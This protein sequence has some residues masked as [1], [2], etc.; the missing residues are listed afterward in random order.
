M[1]PAAIIVAIVFG[2]LVGWGLGF[3]LADPR[4]GLVALVGG[5][6]IGGVILVASLG[7]DPA[8]SGGSLVLGCT[9]GLVGLVPR[10]RKTA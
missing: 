10:L 7:P 5:G 4:P 8:I 2:A 6:V 1:S 9:A 3:R